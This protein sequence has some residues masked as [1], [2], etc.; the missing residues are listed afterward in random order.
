MFWGHSLLVVLRSPIHGLGCFSRMDLRAGTVIA[1]YT[2]EL[3]P[4]EEAVRRND[5]SYNRFS[6][7]ILELNRK[8]F[9]DGARLG[10]ESC[11]INHSCDPNCVVQRIGMRAFIVSGRAIFGGEE[12]TIDYS[13]DE[14]QHEP[15]FCHAPNCRGFI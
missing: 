6:D 13:Y 5:R 14:D 3:I 12:L 10:N 11:L 15:C 1:E 2:G 7:F 4:L 9:I 8:V